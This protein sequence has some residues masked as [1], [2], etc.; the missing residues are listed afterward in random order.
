MYNLVSLWKFNTDK[1]KIPNN[2]LSLRINANKLL[3][4]LFKLANKHD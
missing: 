1:K 2:Q 3:K 4:H